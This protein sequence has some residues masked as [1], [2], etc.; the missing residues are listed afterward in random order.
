[1]PLATHNSERES[2][3]FC[4]STGI[5][6]DIFDKIA[7]C[8]DESGGEGTPRGKDDMTPVDGVALTRC[9]RRLLGEHNEPSEERTRERCQTLSD[10]FY[11]DGIHRKACCIYVYDT[12]VRRRA[13]ETRG[14]QQTTHP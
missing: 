8:I 13:V 7:Y 9:S 4:S 10:F 12:A 1:M 6:L 2:P 14:S 3:L 5:T 11:R